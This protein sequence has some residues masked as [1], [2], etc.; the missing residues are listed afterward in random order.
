M[1][2]EAPGKQGTVKRM[3]GCGNQSKH[4]QGCSDASELEAAAALKER[5]GFLKTAALLGAGGAAT[6]GSAGA[7]AWVRPAAAPETPR[8]RVAH[9]YLPATAETVHWGVPPAVSGTPDWS[10]SGQGRG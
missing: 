8:G 5:R 4:D 3:C 7:A 1:P 9:H 10:L 6:L 2:H